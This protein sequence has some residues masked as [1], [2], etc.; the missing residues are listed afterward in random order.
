MEAESGAAGLT[1][2]S[3]R[4]VFRNS[5]TPPISLEF[6]KRASPYLVADSRGV[7]SGGC[8]GYRTAAAPHSP[9]VQ[10]LPLL[11]EVPPGQV[12]TLRVPTHVDDDVDHV[13]LGDQVRGQGQV[14]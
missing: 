4:S 8:R 5:V 11:P 12:A 14:E 6:M 7:S 3:S 1:S 13:L 10:D 9:R 2:W